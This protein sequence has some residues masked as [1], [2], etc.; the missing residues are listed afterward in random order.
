M[1]ETTIKSKIELTKARSARIKA[2]MSRPEFIAELNK[3]KAELA[4]ELLI[5][6]L[7]QTR[8]SKGLTQ[9]K[10]AEMLGVKQPEI[11]RIENVKESIT[12]DTLINYASVLNVKI[13]VIL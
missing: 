4:K 12:I 13:G 3:E 5:L 6:T 2:F 9:K 10:I 7:K 1:S 11:A 8:K